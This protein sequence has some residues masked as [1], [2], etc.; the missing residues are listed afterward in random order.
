MEFIN[1]WFKCF[2]NSI[3]LYNNNIML[4]VG[5]KKCECNI[6]FENIFRVFFFFNYL[7]VLLQYCK[8]LRIKLNFYF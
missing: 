4:N 2:N 6:I 1:H 8:M 3:T 5:V 7:L